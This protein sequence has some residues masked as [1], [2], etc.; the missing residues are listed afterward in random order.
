MSEL[1]MERSKLPL[2]EVQQRVDRTVRSGVRE[3]PSM[4]GE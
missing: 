3:G 2:P 1:N 4:S